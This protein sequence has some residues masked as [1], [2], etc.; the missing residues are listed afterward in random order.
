VDG[1]AVQTTGSRCD[2]WMSD[3]AGLRTAGECTFPQSSDPHN[4]TPNDRTWS[5]SS[6]SSALGPMT[7]G[8]EQEEGAGAF[9]KEGVA[10]HGGTN[11]HRRRRRVFLLHLLL[12]PLLLVVHP[13]CHHRRRRRVFLLLLLLLRPLLLVVHPRSMRSG[14]AA[15]NDENGTARPEP[16]IIVAVDGFVFF[17]FFFF[18]HFFLLCIRDR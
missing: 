14:E 13:R 6:C 11:Q 2:R 10:W 3:G 12:P 9:R 16:A 17:F 7:G 8:G 1:T 4:Q 5:E 18:D 15:E